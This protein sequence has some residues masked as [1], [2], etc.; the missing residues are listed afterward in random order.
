MGTFALTRAVRIRRRAAA[1]LS[2]LALAGVIC[3]S[4]TTAQASDQVTAKAQTGGQ[5]TA[6]A[7]ASDQAAA[8]QAGTGCPRNV[9]GAPVSLPSW[10]APSVPWR[11]VG[12]GWILADLAKSASASGPASLYLVSPGG[13]RYRLGQVPAD[14]TLEDWSGNGTDALFLAQKQNSTT[15]SI[16]VLN[17]RTG[18]SSG[19]TVFSGTPYP[20]ISFSRPTGTAILF[21]GSSSLNGGELPLQRFSLTG[22]PEL[23]YPTQFPR[24]GTIVGNY[25]E[26]A[27]GTELVFGTQDGMEVVSNAGQPI[28]A[29]A[30]R[31]QD[32]CQL[33]NWWNSQSV[34]GDCSGQLLA[35]PLS[36][37][38][39]G[40]LTSS[41]DIGTFL[42]AWHLPSGTYA[43]AAAC[44]TTWLEKLNT[45][46]T[47][48]ILTIPGAAKAGTVQPLGTDGDR[49][50]LL[51]GGGCDTSYAYSLIDWYNPSANQAKTVLGG[52]AGGG[53]Y[54]TH[55][56]LFPAT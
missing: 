45:N 11:S 24:A 22:T 7:Q 10:T 20:A 21:Q 19:F 54:V 56:V 47:A 17:L 26:N 3:G 48:K 18:R 53:G 34:V 8:S 23:C 6:K 30:L 50:P 51:I 37:G 15:A 49:L 27:N 9:T 38:R 41:R 5:V 4:T 43:E 46:G 33:L 14:V 52:P 1:A 29:L 16:I 39:P 28:R 2:T 40:Q 32:D 35:F 36:G 55:A 13:Q 31:G 42:G 44:G 25:L 12:R